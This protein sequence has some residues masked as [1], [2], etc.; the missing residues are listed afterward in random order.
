MTL[1][2]P[3]ASWL[4]LAAAAPIA[5]SAGVRP[6]DTP[7]QAAAAA[8]QTATVTPKIVAAA[9]AFLAT[10]DDKERAKVS[11]GFES[12]QRTGWSNLPTG[13]FQRNGLRFGDLTQPKRDAA[14]SLVASALS[15]DGL[16]KVN[17]IMNGD[18]FLKNAGGGRT[19]GRQGA[20][21]G[22]AAGGRATTA[23]AAAGGRRRWSRIDP[24][25]AGRVLHRAAR[26]TVRSHAVDDPVRRASPGH[27]RHR[28]RPDQRDDAQPAGR[29]AGQLHAERPDDPAARRGERQGA[30]P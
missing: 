4:L 3:L 15:R 11:F 23:A 14:L 30:S 27:Q 7:S 1:K 2:L 8:R 28:R 20:P 29:A 18:E 25:R 21:G 26:R 5:I 16:R 9:Q 13:I 12:S 10:L 22:A 17:D 19:G 24:V 6:I